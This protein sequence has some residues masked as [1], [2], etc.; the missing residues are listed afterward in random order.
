MRAGQ[1]IAAI[2]ELVHAEQWAHELA[3]NGGNLNAAHASYFNVSRLQYAIEE[4]V[5]EREALQRAL[6]YL[7]GATPQHVGH[8][9]KY[10]RFYQR[11]IRLLGGNPV[12]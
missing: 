5:T 8:S 11:R 7:G 9:M 3:R 4:V 2:H 1:L 6:N 10:I 12:P